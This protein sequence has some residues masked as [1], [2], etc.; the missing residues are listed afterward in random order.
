[1]ECLQFKLGGT[2]AGNSGIGYLIELSKHIMSL[3]IKAVLEQLA[4]MLK[5]CGIVQG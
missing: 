4:L 5:Y 3:N 2:R 1:M